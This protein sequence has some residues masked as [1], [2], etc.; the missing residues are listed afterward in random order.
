VAAQ[1]ENR[2]WGGLAFRGVIAILFGILAMARPG[3]T[4]TGLV[5]LFGAFVFIDGIFAIA[6]SFNVAQMGGRWFS[7]LLVGLAGVVI[8]V[9]SFMHPAVT[10]TGLVYYLAIWALV[11]GVLEIAAAFRLRKVVEGEWML[12]VAGLLSIA[13]GIM[14]AAR[15]TVGMVSLVWLIGAYAIIFGALEIGLAFRLRGVEH[16]LATS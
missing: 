14:I 7:L 2:T 6:A 5:Y 13:F 16:H 10:A 4:V 3:I 11:T 1:F 9:L 12:A 15:P 8:G